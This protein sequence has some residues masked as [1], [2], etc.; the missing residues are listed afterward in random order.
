MKNKLF[1][2]LGVVAIGMF[3]FSSCETDACK[4]VE[5]GANGTCVDGDCVCE[6][7]YE[8]LSCQTEERAKFVATYVGTIGIACPGSGSDNLTN[9]TITV[10]NSSNVNKVTINIAGSFTLTATVSGTSM[11]IDN[12]SQDG[13]NYSGNGS[14]NGNVLTINLNEEEPGVETCVYSVNATKQ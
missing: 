6:T 10:G 3:S 1:K 11:T 13:L 9:Q 14:V 12:S 7:G 5:C 4:D 2:I 8:G